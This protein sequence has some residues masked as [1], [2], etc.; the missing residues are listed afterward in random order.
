MRSSNQKFDYSSISLFTNQRKERKNSSILY[1]FF[2][3][4]TKQRFSLFA[5]VIAKQAVQ[6]HHITETPK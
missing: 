4:D 3:L 5:D 1:I 2:L 6:Q